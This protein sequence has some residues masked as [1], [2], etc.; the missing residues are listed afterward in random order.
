MLNHDSARRRLYAVLG[1]TVAVATLVPRA[2]PPRSQPRRALPL[3]GWSFI[4]RLRPGLVRA[5]RGS[6][7][8]ET[9]SARPCRSGRSPT[10]SSTPTSGSAAYA[11]VRCAAAV[12][13]PVSGSMTTF[14]LKPWRYSQRDLCMWVT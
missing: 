8:P 4:V 14:V 13:M 5:L 6:T 9:A 3:P 10:T 2:K 7:E 12:R 1:G 11:G